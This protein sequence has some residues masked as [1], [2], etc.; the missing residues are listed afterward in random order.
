MYDLTAED[1]H[2][3]YLHC[4]GLLVSNSPDRNYHFR[5][6]AHEATISQYNQVFG[7]IWEDEELKEFLERGLDMINASPPKTMLTT[8]TQLVQCHPE[9]R[10]LMLNGAMLHALMALVINWVADEF[11]LNGGT[12]VQVLLP[13]GREVDLPIETLYGVIYEDR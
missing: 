2:N 9:W 7:F 4:S 11:S 1:W 8:C 5:P 6:P 10:T 3:F 13:D 12:V